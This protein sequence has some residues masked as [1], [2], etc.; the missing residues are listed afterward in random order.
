MF[1]LSYRISKFKIYATWSQ[2]K[3]YKILF[4]D[5]LFCRTEIS[6]RRRLGAEIPRSRRKI[7]LTAK[8]RPLN[9]ASREL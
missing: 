5:D 9:S 2:I 7:P 6:Q 1:C 3:F 4:R 8:F